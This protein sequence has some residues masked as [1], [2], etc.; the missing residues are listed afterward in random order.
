MDF[1]GS[2][3]GKE[4][5]YQCRR[6]KRRGFDPWVRKIPWRKTWQPIQYSCLENPMD[7]EAWQATIHRVAKSQTPLMQLRIHACD[8]IWLAG[9]QRLEFLIPNYL[10]FEI[11][12]KF[13]CTHCYI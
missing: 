10:N 9:F 13:P 2:I 1:P 11:K 5:A 4:P 12:K 8:I 6:L 3:C 7:R